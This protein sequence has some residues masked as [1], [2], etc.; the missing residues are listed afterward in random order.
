MEMQYDLTKVSETLRARIT[1][2]VQDY[3][4]YELREFE[5][6]LPYFTPGTKAREKMLG[7]Q[8]AT[9]RFRDE[10]PNMETADISDLGMIPQ[11]RVARIITRAQADQKANDRDDAEFDVMIESGWFEKEVP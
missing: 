5:R 4:A 9:K 2:D 1:R 6:A 3:L 8:E 7:W 11:M 10:I